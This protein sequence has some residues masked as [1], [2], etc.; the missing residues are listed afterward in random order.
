MPISCLLGLVFNPEDEGRHIPL[1]RWLVYNGL[2]GAIS[3]KILLFITTAVK[4]SNATQQS[5]IYI[6]RQF[7]SP[8]GICV[9]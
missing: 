6:L 2:H 8:I 7:D 4:N 1:K 5:N 3:Q 9:L